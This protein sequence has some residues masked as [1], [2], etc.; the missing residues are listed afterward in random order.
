MRART[1][2]VILAAMAGLIG[3]VKHSDDASSPAHGRYLGVGVYAPG[4]LWQKMVVD[5]AP[6]QAASAKLLDDEQVIVVVDS[7]TGEVRQCGNL[8]GYCTGLNPWSK[9]LAAAQSAPVALTIHADQLEAQDA[10]ATNAKSAI[11]LSH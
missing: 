8:S 6:K 1:I 3:C 11:T 9:S 5:G 10:A 4:A 7:Q 2:I